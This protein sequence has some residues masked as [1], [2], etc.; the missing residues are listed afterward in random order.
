MYIPKINLMTEPQEAI[1]FMQRYNFAT[2]VTVKDGVP[3]ATHL[4]FVIEQRGEKIVLISHFAKANPQA[5]ELLGC[6]PLVIFAEPHA[7]I[8]TRHYEHDVNVPTWNY[9]AVHAYGHAVLLESEEEKI[10]VLERSI[11]AFEAE[12]MQQ[13]NALPHDYK[14]GLMKGI[15]AFEIVVDDLQAKKKLSQN[16][17]DKERRS[18]IEE[19]GKSNDTTAKDIADR[20]QS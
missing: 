19:L 15:T 11:N 6:K 14:Y 4:P 17:S 10:A 3:N 20:M 9:I 16:R 18:I 1:S 8:S 12:Y 2:I 7:Y 13:W 5:D